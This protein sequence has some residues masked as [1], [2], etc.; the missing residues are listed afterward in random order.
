MKQS[1][2]VTVL[3]LL[4]AGVSAIVFAADDLPSTP[5]F[6]RYEPMMKRSPFAVATAVAL[7]SAT[8]NFAKDLYIANAART[9]KGDLITVASSTDKNFKEYLSTNQPQNGYAIVRVEWSDK[10]GE[11]KVTISKDG[12]SATLTFNQALLSQSAA[13][14]PQPQPQPQ[15]QVP[16][17]PGVP[18]VPQYANPNA[19]NPNVIKPAPIPMLPTPPPR[20][21]G[22]IPRRP[23]AVV[24]PAQVA[25]PQALEQ[26]GKDEKGQ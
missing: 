9:P 15:Q 7:P 23:N 26:G 14:M 20:T 19:G 3:T 10:V 24:P 21:R 25:Q 11:T 13:N 6:A 8:P 12:Q 4:F 16:G 22:P 2:A 5:P 17:V 1:L 18:S